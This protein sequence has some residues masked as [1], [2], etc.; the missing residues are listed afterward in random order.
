MNETAPYV[1]RTDRL[2][3]ITERQSDASDLDPEQLASLN[4]QG[5]LGTV[6]GLEVYVVDGDALRLIDQSFTED[7]NGGRYG[8]CPNGQLWV[9]QNQ[10]VDLADTSAIL[11]HGAVEHLEMRDA[12]ASYDQGHAAGQDHERALRLALQTGEQAAP[13]TIEEA[14]AV[15]NDWATKSGHYTPES[16]KSTLPREPEEQ[17]AGGSIGDWAQRTLEG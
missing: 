7:A 11:L 15:A 6:G 14:I 3:Y 13:T 10:L 8:Y 5:P 16:V 17:A 12:G 2:N 9:E 1:E 4:L